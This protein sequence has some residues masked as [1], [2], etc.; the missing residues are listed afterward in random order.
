[1]MQLN[2]FDVALGKHVVRVSCNITMNWAWRLR[3]LA[4]AMTQRSVSGNAAFSNQAIHFL[5][6]RTLGA[7]TEH[8]SV[9]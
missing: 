3:R 4:S 9:E 1:M 5:I 6:S 7:S 2:C 8:S